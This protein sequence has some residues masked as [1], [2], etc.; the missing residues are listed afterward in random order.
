M[1]K[2]INFLGYS[3]W[4]SN[5]RDHEESILIRGH[6]QFLYSPGVL[7]VYSF[8]VPSIGVILYGINLYR[9]D[10]Q[11]KGRAFIITSCGFMFLSIFFSRHN[12]QTIFIVKTFS[13]LVALSLY[14]LEKPHFNRAMRNG[15]QKA[16]WWPP[17]IGILISWLFAILFSN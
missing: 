6:N 14:Q 7:A 9:R 15:F 11:L 5:E 8:L 12:A 2:H 1:A 10:E 4:I 3:T 17:L 13:L 16:R